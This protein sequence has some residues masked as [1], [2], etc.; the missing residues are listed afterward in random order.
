VSPA[1]GLFVY[2]PV[3]LLSVVGAVMAVRQRATR[4]IGLAFAAVVVGQW[5]VV[6]LFPHWWGGWSYGPRFMSDVLP[7]LAVFLV[8]VVDRA[9]DLGLRSAAGAAVVGLFVVL[10]GASA[11]IHGRAAVSDAPFAWN[12]QPTSVDDDP[13]RL[14]DWSDP[15]FLR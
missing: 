13:G 3:L 4:S 6:S 5:V 10:L 12:K 14:W 8:P 9:A 7:V 2:S 1:R 11:V 15:A